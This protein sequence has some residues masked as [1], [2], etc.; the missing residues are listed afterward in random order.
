MVNSIIDSLID[1]IIHNIPFR[2]LL[3]IFTEVLNILNSNQCPK[4]NSAIILSTVNSIFLAHTTQYNQSVDK[5]GNTY[6]NHLVP[7]GWIFL[8]CIN[9][10]YMGPINNIISIFNSQWD[11]EA[12]AWIQ[13]QNIATKL[14]IGVNQSSYSKFVRHIAYHVTAIIGRTSWVFWTK[15]DKSVKLTLPEAACKRLLMRATKHKMIVMLLMRG[16]N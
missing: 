2:Q 5:I 7:W 4:C 14:S 13:E 12:A 11:K 16:K 15:L 1:Q 6:G 10:I 9:M 8:H 3:A